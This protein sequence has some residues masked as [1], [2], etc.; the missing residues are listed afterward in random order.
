MKI[1][2]TK[3]QIKDIEGKAVTADVSKDLG[4][5]MYFGDKD[6]AVADLGHEIYHKGEVDLNREQAQIV[7]AYVEEGFVAVVRRD[8]IPLLDSVK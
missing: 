6:I 3:V 5:M 8:L 1:D 7:K 4:N 2:F